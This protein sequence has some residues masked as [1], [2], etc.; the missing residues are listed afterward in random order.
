MLIV[1]L[2]TVAKTWKPPNCPSIDNLTKKMYIY[3]MGDYSAV[4]K[5]E[6]ILF[7]TTWMDLK[8]SMLREIR[9]SGKVKNHMVS[10]ICDI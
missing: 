5:D 10:L 8:N 6:I 3:T 7:V 4:R 1:V 9:Q 2:F